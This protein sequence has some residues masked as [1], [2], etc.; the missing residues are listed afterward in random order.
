MARSARGLQEE[1]R[2]RLLA[3]D[4]IGVSGW[5]EAADEYDCLMDP[6][7]RQ[8][9][10][11]ASAGTIAAWLCRELGEHFG[12]DPDPERETALAA[13]LTAWWSAAAR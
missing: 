10:D 8:L 7:V 3:W 13:E 5:P 1:L 11:G 4:P 2:A 9:D 12:L 6:L